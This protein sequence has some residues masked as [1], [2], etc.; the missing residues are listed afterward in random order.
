MTSDFSDFPPANK[1]IWIQKM[2][3]DLKGKSDYKDLDYLIDFNVSLEA[4][5]TDVAFPV[6]EGLSFFETLS[7][8]IIDIKDEK[9]AN[10]TALQFLN[11]GSDCLQFK[12]N[13]STDFDLLFINIR[14]DYIWLEL[15]CSD[16]SHDILHTL[17]IYLKT[18]YPNVPLKVIY[19]AKK[20]FR[21]DE[22][23]YQ[24]VGYIDSS[25]DICQNIAHLLLYVFTQKHTIDFNKVCLTVS[26]S[27]EWLECIAILRAIRI[28][29][30]NLLEL[31]ELDHQIPLKI[32][33]F[34]DV[35][36][37]HDDKDLQLIALSYK[38]MSA[39]IGGADIMYGI[40]ID[41]PDFLE[42]AR[43]C[44]NM[45]HIY[46]YESRL[47]IVSDPM[48]GSYFIENVTQQIALES[49][50]LFMEKI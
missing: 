36:N 9:I 44:V 14:L 43:L 27:K 31:C 30:A 24:N 39:Y 47:N 22:G 17:E 28:L 7:G 20:E 33:T 48:A 13:D 35:T 10:K 42:N 21:T 8:I 5:Q 40:K 15:D 2:I 16:C 3:A 37:S 12:I 26:I 32:C 25:K 6:T 34:P 38:L 41:N 45:H 46:K 49:W 11:Y 29:W 50:R 1:D 4:A 19:K 23:Y 18:N